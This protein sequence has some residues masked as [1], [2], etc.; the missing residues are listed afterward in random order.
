MRIHVYTMLLVILGDL[1]M[2]LF[3]TLLNCIQST[4]VMQINWAI[5]YGC[6]QHFFTVKTLKIKK[7][8][9]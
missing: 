7:Q 1:V 9:D 6:V 4:K 2:E 5:F 3:N 8:S